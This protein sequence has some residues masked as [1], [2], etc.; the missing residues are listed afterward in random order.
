MANC[1]GLDQP[2]APFGNSPLLPVFELQ[3]SSQQRF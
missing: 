2:F 3:F 1:S